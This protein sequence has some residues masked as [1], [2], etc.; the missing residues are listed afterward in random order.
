MQKIYKCQHKYDLH[1]VGVYYPR[2]FL[3]EADAISKHATAAAYT[4]WAATA[5]PPYKPLTF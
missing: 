1:A 3:R 5:Q 4:V 2:E